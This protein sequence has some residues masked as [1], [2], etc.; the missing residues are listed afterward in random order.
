MLSSAFHSASQPGTGDTFKDAARG[1]AQGL[2]TYLGLKDYDRATQGQ[3][4]GQVI[5]QIAAGVEYWLKYYDKLTEGEKRSAEGQ[6]ALAYADYLRQR[7]AYYEKRGVNEG[8]DAQT[9][10]II[11]ETARDKWHNVPEGGVAIRGKPGQPPESYANPKAPVLSTP[12]AKLEAGKKLVGILNDLSGGQLTPAQQ[13][14]IHRAY[15]G[16]NPPNVPAGSTMDKILRALADPDKARGDAA[17]AEI[18]RAGAI[19]NSMRPPRQAG[20]GAGVATANRLA[21]GHIGDIIQYNAHRYTNPTTGDVDWPRFI[22][23]ANRG[24]LQRDLANAPGQ[25]N[26][27]DIDLGT[28][29]GFIRDRQ[30]PKG[31]PDTA[32]RTTTPGT[33]TPTRP[34]T[35]A[36]FT[37]QM[38]ADVAALLGGGGGDEAAEDEQIF[39]DV[40]ELLEGN[41]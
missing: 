14:A 38:Q 6:R 19:V 40:N 22:S 13:A 10:Q 39:A 31:V 3:Y 11:A 15:N 1:Y 18:R 26:V 37:P 16:A 28:A 36:N 32:T 21:A 2:D 5:S 27:R 9:K 35:T 34:G 12:E 41:Q 4:A 8:I 29:I 23:D 20:A 25:R 24:L 33:T 30:T 7:G 17:I